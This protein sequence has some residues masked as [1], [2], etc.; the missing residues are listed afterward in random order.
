MADEDRIA[1]GSANIKPMS[2][3]EAAAGMATLMDDDLIIDEHATADGSEE[4][5]ASTAKKKPESE[6][7]AEEEGDDAEDQSEKPKVEERDE[8]DDSEETAAVPATIKVKTDAGEEE[9]TAEEAAKGY[10]RTADYTRKSQANAELRKSMETQDTAIKAERAELATSLKQLK[11]HLD[12]IAP[13]EPNWDEIRVKS[14]E[15]F[16][17]IHAEWQVHKSRMDRVAQAEAEARQ[18]VVEDQVDSHN[19]LIEAESAKLRESFPEMADPVKGKAF[20]KALS[21]HA[22]TFGWTD[23]DL[24]NVTDHRLFKL[25]N[26]SRLYREIKGGLDAKQGKPDAKKVIAPTLKP[27]AQNKSPK[28]TVS[29]TTRLK[30]RLAK[31]GNV[32]D[33]AAAMLASGMLD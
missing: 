6:A 12:S 32:R 24:R 5:A 26:E 30:Q 19:R 10:M 20:K 13:K 8:S 3:H 18:K 33:A 29:E 27:G 9:I 22:K 14:P 2:L 15:K 23:D 4:A 28:S 17:A 7:E 11:D 16:A 21:D 25:L 1:G 31:T